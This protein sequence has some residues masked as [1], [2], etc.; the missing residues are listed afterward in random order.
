MGKTKRDIYIN[1]VKNKK[2]EKHK[3]RGQI[4]FSTRK[5]DRFI[6]GGESGS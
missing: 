5:G 3:K 4:Y 1:P 6:L 2:Q